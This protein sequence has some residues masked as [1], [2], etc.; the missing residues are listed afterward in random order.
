MAGGSGGG[1][2]GAGA[3]GT[4]LLALGL[5]AFADVEKGAGQQAADNFQA[6]RATEAAKFGRLQADLADTTAHEKLNV[7]L[8]NIDA[9]RAAAHIDPTSPTTA[10]VEQW[11]TEISERQRLATSGTL[12]AQAATD[13]ASAAYLRKLGSYAQQQGYLNAGIDILGGASKWGG[14]AGGGSLGTGGMGLPAGAA[15]GGLY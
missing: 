9:I 11:Q 6:D 12:R 8:G 7:Q 14:G 1:G 3:S 15:T 13:D 4:S 2:F 10:A 5:S